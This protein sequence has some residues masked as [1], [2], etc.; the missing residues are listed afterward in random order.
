[1]AFTPVFV[2]ELD[3]VLKVEL[4][5]WSEVERDGFVI[6]AY[7][8]GASPSTGTLRHIGG[9]AD[10]LAHGNFHLSYVADPDRKVIRV[11]A[12]AP[13]SHGIEHGEPQ[14]YV[15]HRHPASPHYQGAGEYSPAPEIEVNRRRY[16][17]D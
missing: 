7:G 17:L 16:G 14:P 3:D 2:V 12:G 9:T 6:L 15:C 13:C 5:T 4:A 11:T 10:W 8:L 1:M